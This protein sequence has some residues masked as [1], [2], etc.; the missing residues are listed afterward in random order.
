MGANALESAF[1]APG[2]IDCGY[3][4]KEVGMHQLN[5]NW[6]IAYP[7]GNAASV[8]HSQV[9]SAKVRSAYSS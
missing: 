7:N 8:S 1:A 6:A 9:H 5:R 3:K 4:M 2:L